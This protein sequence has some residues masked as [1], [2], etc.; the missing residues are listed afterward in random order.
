[1]ISRLLD[2]SLAD[3]GTRTYRGQKSEVPRVSCEREQEEEKE[4][5]LT[6]EK[7]LL[8]TLLHLAFDL[9]KSLLMPKWNLLDFNDAG[10]VGIPVGIQVSVW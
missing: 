4:Q 7:H 3:T 5:N 10:W 1:M 9:P 6:M 8:F 2:T